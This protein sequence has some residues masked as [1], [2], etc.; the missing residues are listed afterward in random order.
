MSRRL[1]HRKVARPMPANATRS[2]TR[3]QR[4]FEA[5]V[6]AGLRGFLA[7]RALRDRHAGQLA[8]RDRRAAVGGLERRL[9]PRAEAVVAAE[10]VRQADVAGENRSD[11]EHDQRE[12]HRRRR[13]MQVRARAAVRRMRAPCAVHVH[14]VRRRARGRA[15]RAPCAAARATEPLVAV[16]REVDEPE[17]VG[18]RQ[19]RR[20]HADHPQNLVAV[21]ERLEQ[22]LVLREEAG[23]AGHAGDR[24][25]RRSRTS[26]R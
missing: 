16:E 3:H 24:D 5:G 12:R 11:G 1:S 26:S 21:Q 18:R 6:V 14:V 4:Q 2:T 15:H 9:E 25:R 22:D 8:G 10:R 19:Q 7:G 13:I 23:Q 20:Q 17:H